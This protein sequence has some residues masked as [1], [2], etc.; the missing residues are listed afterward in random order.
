MFYATGPLY[1]REEDMYFKQTQP[2]MG[3]FARLDWSKGCLWDK[4]EAR[5]IRHGPPLIS[6]GNG[7]KGKS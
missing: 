4:Q 5:Q 1:W 3:F 7:P 2:T 6:W